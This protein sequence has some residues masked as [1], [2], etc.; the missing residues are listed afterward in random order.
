[1]SAK[2]FLKISILLIVSP[3]AEFTAELTAALP[4]RTLSKLFYASIIF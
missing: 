1:M 2:I 3:L 4:A